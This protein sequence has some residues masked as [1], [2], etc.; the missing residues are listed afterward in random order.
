MLVHIGFGLGLDG[1][2]L[3]PQ[4]VDPCRQSLTLAQL[5]RF[6]GIDASLFF[7]IEKDHFALGFSLH[8]TSLFDRSVCSR[9][10]RDSNPLD[11]PGRTPASPP[12]RYSD[13]TACGSPGK[14]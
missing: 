9:P 7:Q 5:P 3:P 10:I 2:S 13:R 1:D 8:I 4:I 11:T 14:G 12:V 6:L